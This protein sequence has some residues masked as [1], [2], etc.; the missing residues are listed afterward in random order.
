MR[1]QKGR[2]CYLS[3][4]IHDC[5]LENPIDRKNNNK[6]IC[7]SDLYMS[8]KLLATHRLHTGL[9][10]WDEGDDYSTRR[11]PSVMSFLRIPSTIS[12]PCWKITSSSSLSS[13]PLSSRSS[14]ATMG[15]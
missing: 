7:Y 12:R 3:R 6:K 8:C 4:L 14:A 10:L 5:K 9:T 13:S 2:L 15:G 11:R 1:H